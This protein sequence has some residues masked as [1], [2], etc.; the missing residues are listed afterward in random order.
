[1]KKIYLIVLI[2][3]LGISEGRVTAQTFQF[4]QFYAAPLLLGPTFAGLNGKS[5]AVAI[6]RDQWGGVVQPGTFVTYGFAV[7]HFLSQRNSGIGFTVVRD[8]AGSG[9][10]GATN[11]GLSYSYDY[12]IDRHIHARLG[13]NVNF[14]QRNLN[15]NQLIFG[16][17]M[18]IDDNQVILRG[19]TTEVAPEKIGY[20]DAMG[21]ALIYSNRFWFGATGAHLMM[22]N[23]SLYNY[24]GMTHRLPI[25]LM[26][27]GGYQFRLKDKRRRRYNGENIT[28]T[29]LYKMQGGFKQLD[30]GAYW[31][32]NNLVAGAFYRGIPVLNDVSINSTSQLDSVATQV[33]DDVYRN[34]DAVILMVGYKLNTLRIGYSYDITVSGL[35]KNSSGTHEISIA[36]DFNIRNPRDRRRKRGAVSCPS[37]YIQ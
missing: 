35:M 24:E 13:A 27:Y 15:F 23:T 1:M 11:V 32:K 29:F 4:S 20:L 9:N 16:D 7:D 12:K 25:M 14:T 18:D 2:I 30:I 17:Q 26:A 34:N 37:F 21:S 5:G 3:L 28:A 22:P 36:Y 33:A 6:Y 8:Q 19:P 10:F 31:S